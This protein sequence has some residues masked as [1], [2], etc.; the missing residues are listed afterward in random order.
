M[1]TEKQNPELW[2]VVGDDNAR[3]AE[4]GMDYSHQVQELLYRTKNEPDRQLIRAL[5]LNHVEKYQK[6]RVVIEPVDRL[7][8]FRNDHLTE[9]DSDTLMDFACLDEQAREVSEADALKRLQYFRIPVLEGDYANLSSVLTWVMGQMKERHG[10]ELQVQYL[11]DHHISYTVRVE[12]LVSGE[13]K[14]RIWK[15][16]SRGSDLDAVPV[17]YPPDEFKQSGL[18]NGATEA[19]INGKGIVQLKSPPESRRPNPQR[20]VT[21]WTYIKHPFFAEGQS[22]E[23]TISRTAILSRESA[24]N[25]LRVLIGALNLEKQLIYVNGGFTSPYEEYRIPET[26]KRMRGSERSVIWQYRTLIREGKLEGSYVPPWLFGEGW[27]DLFPESEEQ[28]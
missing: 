8:T 3:L 18:I 25:L 1:R 24:E 2:V 22:I 26:C 19:L 5:V 21:S 9:A 23:M 20:H 13:T 11:P 12:F 28:K 16:V 14:F 17:Y 10:I 15:C 4:I 27:L 7:K 6:Y